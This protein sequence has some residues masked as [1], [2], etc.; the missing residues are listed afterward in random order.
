MKKGMAINSDLMTMEKKKATYLENRK[1]VTP[2]ISALFKD[3]FNMVKR[4]AEDLNFFTSS[5]ALVKLIIGFFISPEVE[6]QVE[7]AKQ[8][9]ALYSDKKRR[10]N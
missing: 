7:Y 5:D 9:Q 3:T 8:I 6:Q 1:K 10:L 2:K 4:R